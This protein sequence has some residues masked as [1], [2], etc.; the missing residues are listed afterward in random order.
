M[1]DP[2]AAGDVVTAILRQHGLL[3]GARLALGARLLS[4][5]DH[6]DWGGATA[7]ARAA[8][9]TDGER[10]L[11]WLAAHPPEQAILIAGN[12]DLARVGELFDIDDDA[13]AAIQADAD[14]HYYGDG[15][16]AAESRFFR[17]CPTLPTTE[18]IA[19]DLSTYRA[20]QRTLVTRLLRQRRLRLAHAEGGL[21]FTHAGVTRRTTWRLGLDDDASADDIAAALNAA[22][23]DAVDACLV[24]RRRRPPD[25][26]RRTPARRRRRRGRRCPLPSPHLRRRGS[27]A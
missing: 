16:A 1:G 11:R 5:G 14:A 4:I 21:L 6:F 12:H 8:A 13:F 17:A 26:S 3:H 22:L 23:D 24:G 20:S 19:R 7:E 25:H 18:I 9:A 2:Q 27:V 15:G 10:T